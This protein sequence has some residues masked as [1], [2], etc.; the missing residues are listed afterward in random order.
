VLYALLAGSPAFLQPG[1][2]S[3]LAVAM[4][5]GRESVPD[6][7]S[8]SVPD[9]VAD[10]IEK[11]MARNPAERWESAE[12]FGH[13]LQQ[14][15]VSI[16]QPITPMTVLGMD[17]TPPRPGLEADGEAPE[18]GG[19]A[20]GAPKKKRSPVLL[21]VGALVLVALVA[22]T[23]F[24]LS[25][26]DDET[27]DDDDETPT[28]TRAE[29]VD[30]VDAADDTGTISLG[31]LEKWEDVDGRLL[32][33]VEGVNTPDVIAAEDAANFLGTGGFTI[34]GI[35]VTLL[36]APAMEAL[37]LP[38][39]ATAILEFRTVTERRLAAECNTALE[40][41][42]AQVAGFEGLLQRFEGC[43]GRALVV[44]AGVDDAGQGLVVEAHLVDDEDEAGIEDVLD[45]IEIG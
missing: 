32:P 10:V 17:L 13:A 29:V 27:A 35:E 11:A 14:A 26:G 36:E 2:T 20:P 24:A 31:R 21:I 19:P 25:G 28:V 5:I 40:P 42:E 4:R 22:G 16:G 30:L 7:R 39:D 45:S 37:T 3:P 15:E 6:I 41:E 1:D 12:A 44:F 18:A 23:F 33:V 34:S 9:I 43:D 8:L 38:A